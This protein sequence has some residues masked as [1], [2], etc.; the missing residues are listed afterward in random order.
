ML[1]LVCVAL[2]IARSRSRWVG[3]LGPVRFATLLDDF[4][5]H[6]KTAALFGV[7]V[8]RQLLIAALLF[9]ALT[10]AKK[11]PSP[12]AGAPKTLEGVL[13]CFHPAS[14]FSSQMK[15]TGQAMIC[16]QL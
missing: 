4:A 14:V 5:H 3:L 2:A 9:L 1:D 8:E 10:T 13:P 16:N 11:K 7:T 12:K 15:F 6:A